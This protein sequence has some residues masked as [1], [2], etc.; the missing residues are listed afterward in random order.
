VQVLPS[1]GFRAVFYYQVVDRG[2]ESLI[3]AGFGT[4]DLDPPAISRVVG[5]QM[6]SDLGR[7]ILLQSQSNLVRGHL[8]DASLAYAGRGVGEV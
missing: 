2:A 1:T 6:P 4:L 3:N 8:L 7:L 5:G